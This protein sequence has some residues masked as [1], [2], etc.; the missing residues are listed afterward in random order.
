MNSRTTLPSVHTRSMIRLHHRAWTTVYFTSR[1]AQLADTLRLPTPPSSRH[2][3]SGAPGSANAARCAAARLVIPPRLP[4]RPDTKYS[5]ALSRIA[6]PQRSSPARQSVAFMSAR[7]HPAKDGTCAAAPIRA[8][9]RS[10]GS[11]ACYNLGD[12]PS[13]AHC[14]RLAALREPAAPVACSRRRAITTVVSDETAS[15]NR[16]RAGQARRD[17]R[18]ASSR[19]MPTT[20]AARISRHPD[21]QGLIGRRRTRGHVSPTARLRPDQ[22]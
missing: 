10:Y 5:T 11:S 6:P 7:C 2:L 9:I 21:E 8:Y 13:F 12:R 19:V 15:W 16:L 17:G 20:A 18:I 3:R 14:K 22:R 1:I 4:G